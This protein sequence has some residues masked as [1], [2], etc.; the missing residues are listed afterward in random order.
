MR[1]T[2]ESL[3]KR[4]T[5]TYSATV[6]C[7]NNNVNKTQKLRASPPIIPPKILFKIAIILQSVSFLLD[8]I[9]EGPDHR[10]GNQGTNSSESGADHLH[11]TTRSGSWNTSQTLLVPSGSTRGL[12]LDHWWV[13]FPMAES[14]S[15][16]SFRS[17][18]QPFLLFAT[19][20]FFMEFSPSGNQ[21]KMFTK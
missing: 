16:I 2:S 5:M 18:G 1:I 15:R 6:T 3:L 13:C 12:P 8:F 19:L 11:C 17:S 7:I 14:Q 4:F 9:R 10:S 21:F 20:L